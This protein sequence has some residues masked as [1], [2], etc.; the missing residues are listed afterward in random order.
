MP[1]SGQQELCESITILEDSILESNEELFVTL[2]RSTM[3]GENIVLS[4]SSAVLTI[5]DNEST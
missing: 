1:G 4:P 2:S 3:D 5:E